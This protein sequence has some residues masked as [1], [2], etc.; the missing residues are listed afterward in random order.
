MFWRSFMEMVYSP[1]TTQSRYVSSM[2]YH[3]W[4]NSTLK[5][6]LASGYEVA[7]LVGSTAR[8]WPW[9]ASSSATCATCPWHHKA[10]ASG[11]ITKYTDRL[12]ICSMMCHYYI[13]LLSSTLT[14]LRLSRLGATGCDPKP[15]LDQYRITVV[16]SA[17][18]QEAPASWWLNTAFTLSLVQSAGLSNTSAVMT[19][20]SGMTK[21]GKTYS[22][23]WKF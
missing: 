9:N 2:M 12:I 17:G 8:F 19:R 20:G 1:N 23:K 18:L 5:H 6:I 4:I 22:L 14:Q 13:S 3:T 15:C 21:T 16:Q 11:Y 7:R 10:H